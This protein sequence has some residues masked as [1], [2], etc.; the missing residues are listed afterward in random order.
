MFITFLFTHQNIRFYTVVL[1][2]NH[3]KTQ[4]INVLSK[5]NISIY[6]LKNG[7]DNPIL[8]QTKQ[9]SYPI[10]FLFDEEDKII[11]VNAPPRSNLSLGEFLDRIE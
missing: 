11:L 3:S 10:C 5:D 2:E 7:I 8:N 4:K 9:L 6:Y 1:L